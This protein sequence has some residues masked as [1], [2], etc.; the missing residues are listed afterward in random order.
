MTQLCHFF[1]QPV[2]LDIGDY[3]QCSCF[4]LHSTLP[5]QSNRTRWLAKKCL[6]RV[7]WR[8]LLAGTEDCGFVDGYQFPNGLFLIEIIAPVFAA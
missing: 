4:R 3:A 6:V 7:K 1:A 2:P 8:Y 5:N